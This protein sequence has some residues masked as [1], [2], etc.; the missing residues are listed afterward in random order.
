MDFPIPSI[1]QELKRQLAL[2]QAQNVLL[3][4]VVEAGVN[5][6]KRL[7]EAVTALEDGPQEAKS[8]GAKKSCPNKYDVIPVLE[9]LLQSNESLPRDTLEK[10]ATDRFSERGW[11]LSGFVRS[12]PAALKDSR[13][14][15]LPSGEVALVSN[16]SR[17]QPVVGGDA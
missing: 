1:V 12:F 10:F 4:N 8:A 9:D 5:F 11:S 15:V 2:A 3:K 13:F 16:A 6:E 17:S 14:Q 7:E